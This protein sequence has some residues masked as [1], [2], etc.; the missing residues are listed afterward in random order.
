MISTD[1]RGKTPRNESTTDLIGGLLSD[2]KDLA[3][4]HAD[5]LKLELKEEVGA[6]KDT[7]KL[8]GIAIAAVVL[9]GLLLTQA[10]VY[11][12]TAA[13]GLPLWASYAIVGAVAAVVGFLAYRGR[14]EGKGA[15]L[16]PDES[17]SS[18]KRDLKRVADAVDG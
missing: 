10:L 15:D 16:V 18:I 13:S 5:Q 1:G 6:L 12:L 8:T 7:I 11:G 3:S 2:A 14:P 9:A 4:A 17:I